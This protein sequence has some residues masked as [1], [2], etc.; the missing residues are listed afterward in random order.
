[1][2]NLDVQLKRLERKVAAGAQFVMTQPIFDLALAKKTFE[3]TRSFGIPL[4][5]G[6]MPLLNSRNTEFLHNEVPGIVIPDYIRERMRGKEGESGF[7]EGLL[8]AR[9]VAAEVLSHFKG[10]YLITPLIRYEATAALSQLIRSGK[11]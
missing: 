6:V 4:L 2:K 11:L 8:I 7:Q 5:I 1:M 9:E 10:I 3:T